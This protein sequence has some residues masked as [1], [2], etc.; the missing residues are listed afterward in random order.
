MFYK[1]NLSIRCNGPIQIF[2]RRYIMLPTF[3]TNKCHPY[4]TLAKQF[5]MIDI[6]SITTKRAPHLWTFV[7]GSNSLL[8]KSPDREPM[9]LKAFTHHGSIQSKLALKLMWTHICWSGLRVGVE[10]WRGRLIR[11]NTHP[12]HW[13]IYMKYLSFMGLQFVLFILQSHYDHYCRSIIAIFTI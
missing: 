13:K 3:T 11:D 8:V 9:R 6:Y 5:K 12:T 4:H 2:A 1:N 7:R 10:W